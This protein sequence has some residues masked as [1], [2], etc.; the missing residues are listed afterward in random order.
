MSSF[1]INRAPVLTLWAAVVAERLGFDRDEALRYFKLALAIDP[2]I[3]VAALYGA[4]SSDDEVH[5]CWLAGCS[6]A[7]VTP[8]PR[9]NFRLEQFDQDFNRGLPTPAPADPP[10]GQRRR[11]RPCVGSVRP[12]SF[13]PRCTCCGGGRPAYRRRCPAGL[14]RYCCGG[15]HGGGL[16]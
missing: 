16:R 10:A 6:S 15:T 7:L 5:Y 1:K 12:R 13:L 14:D 8:V 3:K 4:V 2:A 9:T 11:Y